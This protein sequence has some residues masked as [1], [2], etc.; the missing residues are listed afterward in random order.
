MEVDLIVFVGNAVLELEFHDG[1]LQGL[2]REVRIGIIVLVLIVD[3][4][5]AGV[6]QAKAWSFDTRREA[7][8]W[9]R[10]ENSEQDPQDD[11]EI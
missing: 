9:F 2:N 1:I 10:S 4:P 5:V 11:N 3:P 7:N 6:L 8:E